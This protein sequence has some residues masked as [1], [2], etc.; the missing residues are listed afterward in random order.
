M[1]KSRIMYFIVICTIIFL[2]LVSRMI[3]FV[4]LYVGDILWAIMIFFILRFIYVKANIKT[5]F[6]TSL[7]ICY[8][9]EISQLY[10]SDWINNIR[11]TV[12]GRLILGQGFLW[13]DI[14]SYT[15]GITIAALTAFR[16]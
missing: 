14:V 3:S 13:S 7:A 6:F 4:P 12:I 16:K 10:Q 15:L 11:M 2:G 5:I 9:V 1:K 8:M